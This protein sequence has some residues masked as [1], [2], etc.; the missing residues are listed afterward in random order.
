MLI[1]HAGYRKFLKKVQQRVVPE[2]G[3]L[4]P[5]F[6][7]GTKNLYDFLGD[8]LLVIVVSTRCAPCQDALDVLSNYYQMNSVNTV[9]LVDTPETNMPLFIEAFAAYAEVFHMETENWKKHFAGVPWATALD[10]NG[11]ILQ[12]VPFRSL[13]TLMPVLDILNKEMICHDV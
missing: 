6:P 4:L 10:R 3:E 7:V 13:S 8:G 12:S 9:M 11:V 2:V 1:E 5:D